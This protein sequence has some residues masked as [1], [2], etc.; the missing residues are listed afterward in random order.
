[1]VAISIR[2]TQRGNTALIFAVQVDSNFVRLL[3]EAGANKDIK[4]KVRF[5][6][7]VICFVSSLH[8]FSRFCYFAT[9]L[10][11]SSCFAAFFMSTEHLWL[12][13]V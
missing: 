11:K 1:M 9:H 4:D 5:T 7:N 2:E 12:G 13:R 10:S 8:S 6:L 3:L